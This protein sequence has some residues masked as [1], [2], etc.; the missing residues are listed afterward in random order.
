MRETIDYNLYV[1]KYNG[2]VIY[3]D[4]YDTYRLSEKHDT[5]Y[6]ITNGSLGKDFVPFCQLH[7]ITS[8]T[9]L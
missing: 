7:I 5:N 3:I 4:N 9:S 6:N 8:L 1:C 2:W